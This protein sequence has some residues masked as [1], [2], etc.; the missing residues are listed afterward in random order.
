M[1]LAIGSLESFPS[2][3]PRF[4]LA[5]LQAHSYASNFTR[6]HGAAAATPHHSRT[7]EP[8][9]RRR[10]TAK[11]LGTFAARSAR[12]PR[13]RS[14]AFRLRHLC[15]SSKGYID[16]RPNRQFSDEYD[17]VSDN[18]TVVL[19]KEEQAV[20]SVR[21]C[22]MAPHA[23][24]RKTRHLPVAHVFPTDMQALLKDRSKA[25][26]I[27]RLVCHP[28]HDHSPGLVFMLM[29]MADYVIRQQDPD[30]VTSC[31]RSN[32]VS[33]YKRLNLYDIA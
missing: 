31:V 6:D 12:D 10:W 29:R 32:H 9:A 19:Y 3:P 5:T 25:V 1:P 23:R 15:Y 17:S 24:R 22:A 33:F 2:I 27:N 28:D 7:P 30:F 18:T 4:D 26:E 21:V 20:G 16:S 14:D 13:T 8:R 11:K